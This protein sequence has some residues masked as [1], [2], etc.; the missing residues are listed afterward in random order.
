MN[1]PQV[2]QG[3]CE[4]PLPS[5]EEFAP[6]IAKCHAKCPT[7]VYRGQ[8]DAEWKL[9]SA[10][11]R[12]EARYLG[13]QKF[14]AGTR[15][16]VEWPLI[17]REQHLEAYK[18]AVRGKRGDNPRTL[19][20]N[21]WWALGQH[22]RLAT[23]LLDWTYSPFVALFFA[24]EEPGYVDWPTTRFV[25]PKER[26]VYVVL[27]HLITKNGTKEHPAPTV[28]SLRREVTHRLTSQ[29]G[30]FM[31]MP[32]RTDLE[33]SVRARFPN[34]TT[35]EIPGSCAILTKIRI[36]NTGRTECLKF[37][38]K[39]NINCQTLFP[40]LDGAARY[41]NSLWELDFDTALGALPEGASNEAT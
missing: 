40:D 9:E 15:G 11:D 8:A 14:W 17:P 27:W 28:F 22:H 20:E 12:L 33:S 3:V 34:Q 6:F 21:E 39:M 38:N 32:P 36:P 37:L 41:I 7:Y 30:L 19:T 31:T 35:G 29:T 18:E 13:K 16:F 4:Q 26:A 1:D 25:E 23:P 24:F 5:W 2:H 10:L